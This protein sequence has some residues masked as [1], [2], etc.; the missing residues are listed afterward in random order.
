MLANQSLL[1]LTLKVKYKDPRTYI[2]LFNNLLKLN[3][4]QNEAEN[5]FFTNLELKEDRDKLVTLI[6]DLSFNLY[7]DNLPLIFAIRS[8]NSLNKLVRFLNIIDDPEIL[9]R[10]INALD[11]SN[12]NA[13]SSYNTQK[14]PSRNI[15]KVDIELINEL[16]KFGIN[17]LQ[18]NILGNIPR[19]NFYELKNAN[20]SIKI[21]IKVAEMLYHEGDRFINSQSDDDRDLQQKNKFDKLSSD[22]KI[23]F[24]ILKFELGNIKYLE[25]EFLNDKPKAIKLFLEFV[26]PE[27]GTIFHRIK[28]DGQVKL[29]I[30]FFGKENFKEYINHQNPLNGNTPLHDICQQNYFMEHY[31]LFKL[32]LDNGA[33]L[34]IKNYLFEEPKLLLNSAKHLPT[35]YKLEELFKKYNKNYATSLANPA[36]RNSSLEN[37]SLAS[38]SSNIPNSILSDWGSFPS[39]DENLFNKIQSSWSKNTKFPSAF[40]TNQDQLFDDDW[41]EKNLEA[42]R[43]F[44]LGYEEHLKLFLGED[45]YEELS[46]EIYDKLIEK[47]LKE[48]IEEINEEI[49]HEKTTTSFFISS[50][51]Q[52]KTIDFTL[53][54]SSNLNLDL[55]LPNLDISPSNPL[56]SQEAII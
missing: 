20:S 44:N 37:D 11:S 26:D 46:V 3:P 5:Q 34:N 35:F 27:F 29:L 1:S 28:N 53:G 10:F 4:L 25:D 38:S 32:L 13:L 9:N 18:K 52:P 51:D 14:Q 15:I 54:N 39:F 36:S 42:S 16:I 43:R 49:D 21:I 48:L 22:D 47:I 6:L 50:E 55:A 12:N 7:K 30:N 31:N 33:D 19:S 8:K 24:T 17:P 56:I 40:F 45:I 2:A 41:F 23:L